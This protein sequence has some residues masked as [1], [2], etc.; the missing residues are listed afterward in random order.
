MKRITQ[1]LASALFILTV[2]T[3]YLAFDFALTSAATQRT[4]PHK[5]PTREH[6]H[7]HEHDNQPH[8]V[9]KSTRKR[10]ITQVIPYHGN[11]SNQTLHKDPNGNAKHPL[12]KPKIQI[13]AKPGSFHKGKTGVKVN[14]PL[15]SLKGQQKRLSPTTTSSQPRDKPHG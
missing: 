8:P 11:T 1:I 5:R 7:E 3:V 14:K 12:P 2:L 9:T 15:K 13:R 6:E 4:L 10:S